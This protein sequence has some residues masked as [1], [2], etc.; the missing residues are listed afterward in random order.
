LGCN[1]HFKSKLRQNLH[2]EFSA[3]NVVFC[4]SSPDPL[5]SRRPPHA[6]VKEGYPIK[7][8]YFV[9]LPLLAHLALADRHWLVAYRN[10]NCWQAFN[11][12]IL[13]TLNDLEPPK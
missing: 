1:A 8:H 9:I 5:G 3:L 12:S 13:M 11:D 4:S 10:N 6:S 7:G 2:V